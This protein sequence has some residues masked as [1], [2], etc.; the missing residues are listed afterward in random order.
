VLPEFEPN[1]SCHAES[2]RQVWKSGVADVG[3]ALTEQAS[4]A[5]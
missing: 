3:L 4:W 5:C 2:L 1:L